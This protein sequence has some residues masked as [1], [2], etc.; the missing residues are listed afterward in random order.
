ML[1]LSLLAFATA[2]LRRPHAFGAGGGRWVSIHELA[3]TC[4]LHGVT[5]TSGEVLTLAGSHRLEFQ[6]GGQRVQLDGVTIWMHQPMTRWNG[7]WAVAENDVLG[8]MDP[9]LRP[10]THLAPCG[11]VKVLLD[12]GHGGED[13]GCSGGGLMEKDVALDLAQR[14][15]KRLEEYGFETKLTRTDDTFVPLDERCQIA[16]EW[17]ADL[18]VSIHLNS[19]PDR[20]ASGLETYV[21]SRAGYAST[22]SDNQK[23]SS[24]YGRQR[25]NTNDAASAV[26]GYFIQRRA[27]ISSRETDRGL[28]HA[29]FLVLRDAPCPA[30]LVE[31]AFLSNREEAQ[32]MTQAE[33]RDRLADGIALGIGQYL[34]AVLQARL[35][36]Y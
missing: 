21:L 24:R 4:R 14:V 27:L 32:K 7:R 18:M 26:L 8:L 9:I 1:L 6:G 22:N 11:A 33:P 31:C 13:G 10:A 5:D 17:K 20:K 35:T 28:R 15:Q 3:R 19:S 29:R 16:S 30:A 23:P 12:P 34:G 36:T 25:G 2:G